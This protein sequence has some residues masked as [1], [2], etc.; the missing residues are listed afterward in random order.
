LEPP[1]LRNETDSTR[2]S[3]VLSIIVNKVGIV[4]LDISEMPKRIELLQ[5]V[6]VE[7]GIT[8]TNALPQYS[9]IHAFVLYT[10]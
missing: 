3:G 9:S 4:S 8:F 10:F 6:G 2:E 7:Y 5:R 1:P